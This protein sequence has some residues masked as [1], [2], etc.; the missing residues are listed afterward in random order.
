VEA[1]RRAYSQLSHKAW[2]NILETRSGLGYRYEQGTVIPLDR[3]RT[4]P[5]TEETGV[6]QP[7]ALAELNLSV[8]VRGHQIA[9]INAHKVEK[10]GAWTAE[11]VAVMETLAQQLG[12]A[13]ESAR[14]YQDTQRRAAREQVISTI[15]A[16]VRE[17]LDVE[18]VLKTAASEMRQALGLKRV[19]VQLTARE[20]NTNWD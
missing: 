5:L 14:L 7:Y 12:Q 8:E 1:E 3:H 6:E 16:R 19:V 4:A 13:L 9:S 20:A 11:E 18:T 15:A 10:A 2:A 17:T